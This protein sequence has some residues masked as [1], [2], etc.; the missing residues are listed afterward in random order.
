V[1]C[2]IHVKISEKLDISYKNR[3]E[4]IICFIYNIINNND[5]KYNYTYNHSFISTDN[6]KNTKKL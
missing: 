5:Y 2:G 3:I 4:N 1:L 6:N